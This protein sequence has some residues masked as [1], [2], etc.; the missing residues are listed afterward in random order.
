MGEVVGDALNARSSLQCDNDIVHCEMYSSLHL[1]NSWTSVS[2]FTSNPTVSSKS[3]S[4]H[5]ISNTNM[6]PTWKSSKS[7]HIGIGLRSLRLYGGIYKDKLCKG[8]LIGGFAALC[9]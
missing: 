5:E 2:W 1:E 3:I 7:Y 8:H 6:R 9:A 4:L